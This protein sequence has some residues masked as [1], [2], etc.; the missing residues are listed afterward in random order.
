V[1]PAGPHSALTADVAERKHDD[2]CGEKLSMPTTIVGQNGA[3]I[4]QSTKVA[5]QG[6]AAVKGAKTKRL[7]RAQ[8]LAR[9]LAACRAKH[10]RAKAA[11]AGCERTARRK[12]AAKLVSL[13]RLG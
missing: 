1:L 4:E 3:T 10:K 9:A 8:Q 11:R 2:L 13:R 6:C 5:I 7:T 12:Y